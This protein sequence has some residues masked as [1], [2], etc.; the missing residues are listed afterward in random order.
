IDTDEPPDTG[1][2]ARRPLP[3]PPSFPPMAV[4]AGDRSSSKKLARSATLLSGRAPPG[5]DAQTL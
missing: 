2:F 4:V 3:K 1:I 5:G